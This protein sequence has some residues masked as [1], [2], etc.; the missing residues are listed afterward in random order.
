VKPQALLLG[1][2]SRLRFPWLFALTAAL[3]LIDLVV[4]DPLPFFDEVF[5][6]LVALLFGTWKRRQR[7]RQPGAGDL[8]P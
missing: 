8:P 3:F 5:L 1:L 6:G 7:G 4:P 2:A